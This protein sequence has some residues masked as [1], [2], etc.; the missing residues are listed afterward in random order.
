MN[1]VMMILVALAIVV[2]TTASADARRYSRSSNNDISADE[3]YWVVLDNGERVRIGGKIV[4]IN[5]QK[6]QAD[7]DYMTA[8]AKGK[9]I[10][11]WEKW[12][13]VAERGA[14]AAERARRVLKGRRW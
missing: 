5:V 1:K 6:Q 13:K 4:A 7:A 2:A 10:E 14:R 3:V 12:M 11:N 8:E 9:S